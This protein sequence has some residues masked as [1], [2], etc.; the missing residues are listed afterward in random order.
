VGDGPVEAQ[1]ADGLLGE[2]EEDDVGGQRHQ[3]PASLEVL[4]VARGLH[5]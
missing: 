5:G 3:V 4:A 2:A 1:L